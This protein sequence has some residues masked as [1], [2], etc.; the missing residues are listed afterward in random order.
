MANVTVK[1]WQ[2]GG[3]FDRRMPVEQYVAESTESYS[4]GAAEIARDQ[5]DNLAHTLGRLIEA[6][7]DNGVLDRAS[8]ER[9]V[10]K[11]APTVVKL[12]RNSNVEEI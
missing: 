10:G 2:S 6:L 12:R 7:I 8:L 5:A 9:I 3:D 11:S 4:D 1:G